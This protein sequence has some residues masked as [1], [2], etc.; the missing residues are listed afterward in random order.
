LGHAADVSPVSHVPLPQTGPVVLPP[1][2]PQS[3]VQ[4]PTSL[5]EQTL[6]PQTGAVLTEA[7]GPVPPGPV[8]PPSPPQLHPAIVEQT[9]TRVVILIMRGIVLMPSTR[10]TPK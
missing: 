2:L 3:A 1:P 10:S 4:L 9:N 6:S 8:P 5:A 7:S